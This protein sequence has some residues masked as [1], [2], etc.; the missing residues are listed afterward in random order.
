MSEIPHNGN[1]TVSD[2]GGGAGWACLILPL[3]V[4]LL[5]AASRCAGMRREQPCRVKPHCKAL[6]KLGR[7]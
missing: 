6:E 3:T 1:G 4:L 5:S 2:A 7:P